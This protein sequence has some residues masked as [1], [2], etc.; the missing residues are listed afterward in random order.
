MMTFEKVKN[1][2]KNKFDF[3]ECNFVLVVALFILVYTNIH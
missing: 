2:S 1:K 3:G